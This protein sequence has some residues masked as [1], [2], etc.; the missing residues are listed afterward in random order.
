MSLPIKHIQ[1]IVSEAED[2]EISDYEVRNNLT[3]RREWMRNL[4]LREVRKDNDG[5]SKPI[6]LHT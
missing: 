2:L 5:N 4:I 6:Q 1:I 3:N